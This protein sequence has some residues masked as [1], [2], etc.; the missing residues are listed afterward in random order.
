L[1]VNPHRLT[2][3][4]LCN[5]VNDTPSSVNQP[6]GEFD[7]DAALLRLR[8]K[9]GNWVE[10]G[11]SCQKLQ[12]LSYTPQQIFEATGFE[13][14]QQNQIIVASQVYATMLEIG[15]K[16]ATATH[17]SRVGSDSLYELRI[18]SKEDRAAVAD[19]LFDRNLDSEGSKEVTKAVKEYA[20]LRRLPENFAQ[21]PG[22]AVAYQYWRYASQQNN[23][24]EKTRLVARGLVFA[25]SNG[26]RQELEKLL[27]KL[28]IAAV[29]APKMPLYRLESDEELPAFIPVA[30]RLPIETAALQGVPKAATEGAFDILHTT[31]TRWVGLPGW[32]A[33]RGA[34]DPVVLLVA[35]QDL[36]P[37][38]EAT[39]ELLV[40]ID[41][42]ARDWDE[43]KYYAVDNGGQVAIKW[44]PQAPPEPLLGQVVLV[45]RPKRMLTSGNP[46]DLWQMEE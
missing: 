23:L 27:G 38:A 6:H 44:Y 32:Q 14:I 10:W 29:A 12:K 16:E 22:D 20:D 13:P 9:E 28:D 45:L 41:R 15:V 26:A 5:T 4:S 21:H 33:V 34:A 36:L 46:N 30:G 35:N 17:Y 40:L 18:L 7:P 1:L 19:F 25:H 39:E 11:Q 24:M 3:F 42:A 2:I 31:W 8:R 43:F 37:D